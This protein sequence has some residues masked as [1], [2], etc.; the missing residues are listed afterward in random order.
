MFDAVRRLRNVIPDLQIILPLAAAHLRTPVEQAIDR[1][2]LRGEIAVIDRHVHTALSKCECVLL[3][4]GTATLEVALLGIP[5]VVC[6]RVTPFTYFL[7]RHLV[8]TRFIAMPNI[9]AGEEIIPELLQEKV[10]G[11]LLAAEAMRIFS[12]K[13]YAEAMRRN[14]GRILPQLGEPG[15]LRRVADAVYETA[16]E[17]REQVRYEFVP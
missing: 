1:A 14:L 9:L 12:D 6:Y 11:E 2:G 8:K 17:A 13:G 16:L 10:T 4:S 15:V 7:G 3:S 5:M